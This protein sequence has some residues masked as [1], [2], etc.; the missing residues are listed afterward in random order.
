MVAIKSKGGGCWHYDTSVVLEGN[1]FTCQF[2]FDKRK[3]TIQQEY[4]EVTG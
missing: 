1:S 4:S 3:L 2:S